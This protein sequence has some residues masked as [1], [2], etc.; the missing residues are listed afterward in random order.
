MRLFELLEHEFPQ[1]KTHKRNVAPDLYNYEDDEA[2]IDD[3]DLQ[4][5][6]NPHTYKNCARRDIKYP[7]TFQHT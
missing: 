7:F 6:D 1:I 3:D 2:Y 4:P 5:D